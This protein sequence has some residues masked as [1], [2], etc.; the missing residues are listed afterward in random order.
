MANPHI[1]GSVLTWS[2]GGIPYS[3]PA[4]PDSF[5]SIKPILVTIVIG[6]VPTTHLGDP[7]LHFRAYCIPAGYWASF[8]TEEAQL[9]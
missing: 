4:L 2:A 9:R 6:L 5:L 1:V 8:Q 7:R 3:Y